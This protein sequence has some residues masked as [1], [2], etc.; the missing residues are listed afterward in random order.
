MPW[1]DRDLLARVRAPRLYAGLAVLDGAIACTLARHVVHAFVSAPSWLMCAGAVVISF[2]LLCSWHRA[3]FACWF[4][5]GTVL[6]FGLPSALPAPSLV[7]VTHASTLSR[8]IDLFDAL[9]KLDDDPAALT[10][11]RITVTGLWRP[12]VDGVCAAVFRRVMA[13]C[14]ADSIDVGFDVVPARAIS[15]R[16][17]VPVQVSGEVESVVRDGEVRYRLRD[18]SVSV[19]ARLRE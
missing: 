7:V 3:L 9:E 14:A 11:R 6:G 12:S 17:N 19:V 1:S 13:C 15:L 18:A 16:A 2:A 4:A 5:V 8:G 10:G